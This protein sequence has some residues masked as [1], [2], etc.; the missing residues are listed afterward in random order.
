MEIQ[1]TQLDMENVAEAFNPSFPRNESKVHVSELRDALLETLGLRKGDEDELPKW[2]KNLGSFGLIWEK[3]LWD[4]AQCEAIERDLHF[5]RGNSSSGPI[6]LE[7]DGV[8]GSLD[9]II[10]TEPGPVS[11]SRPVAV[12]ECKTRWKAQELPTENDK[13]MIQAKAYCWMAGVT[14]CWF[15]V[16]NMGGRPPDMTQWL[17]IIDFSA[18]ELMENWQ[19]LLRMKPMVEK[20]KYG[21]RA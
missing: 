15:P 12:W 17:H 10:Y 4:V 3:V 16:L 1:S 20:R 7:T 11:E 2:V 9:G 21:S 6:I 8:I 19:S 18:Q 14:Q 5:S 13:Y